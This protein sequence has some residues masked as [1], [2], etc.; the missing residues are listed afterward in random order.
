M[1]AVWD[2]EREP[3]LASEA[4][5]PAIREL[6]A[7]LAE[8]SP[9]IATAT[10]QL[11]GPKGERLSLPA[12]VFTL[13]VRLV[14][15]L[16][17][18]RAVTVM[19]IEAELT[20]QQAADLLQVS[21]PFLVKLLESGEIPFHLVGTHRRIALQDLLT[22]RKDRSRRRQEFFARAAHEAQDMGIYE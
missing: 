18:G 1:A 2:R 6:E 9:E 12:P 17:R 13:L 7:A 20:T 8:C 14:H 4:D 21:R 5:A 22:Y 10:A 11:L 16:A 15:D 3:V 19:P